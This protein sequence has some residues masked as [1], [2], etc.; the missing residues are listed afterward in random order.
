MLTKILFDFDDFNHLGICFFTHRLLFVPLPEVVSIFPVFMGVGLQDTA[1]TAPTAF[2]AYNQVRSP[3]EFRLY[4]EAGH[5][6][7]QEHKVLKMQ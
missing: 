5:S 3:K 6:T 1:A 2:S 7:P 4:P